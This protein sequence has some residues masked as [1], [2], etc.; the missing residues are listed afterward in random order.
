[1]SLTWLKNLFKMKSPKQAKF[2]V[3]YAGIHVQ[4]LAEIT[5]FFMIS[6]NLLCWPIER[7]GK[8]SHLL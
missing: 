4:L 7:N 1:M 2:V 5:D 3:F 6:A 8:I